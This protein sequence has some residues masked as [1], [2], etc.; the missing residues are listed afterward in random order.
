M[1]NLRKHQ[2]IH[3]RDLTD[4]AHHI[5]MPQCFFFVC[6]FV[7]SPPHISSHGISCLFTTF[8]ITD[9][10]MD[11]QMLSFPLFLHQPWP[12]GPEAFRDHQMCWPDPSCPI[13]CTEEKGLHYK[14]SLNESSYQPQSLKMHSQVRDGKW[15]YFPNINTYIVYETLKVLLC[16]FFS[17]NVFT[18]YANVIHTQYL[19]SKGVPGFIIMQK[20]FY[21]KKKKILKL[22]QLLL[23]LLWCFLII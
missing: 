15:C 3:R 12:K 5:Y 23:K 11:E 9:E 19:P 13:A 8:K 16:T 18:Q 1:Y 2:S 20:T 22:L 4:A 6:L 14:T 21:W 10:W 7:V 17:P